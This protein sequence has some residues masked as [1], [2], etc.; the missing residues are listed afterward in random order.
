MNNSIKQWRQQHQRIRDYSTIAD[1]IRALSANLYDI[2]QYG[3][4]TISPDRYPL[5]SVKTKY[6][7]NKPTIFLSAL[8]HGHEINGGEALIR[9]LESPSSIPVLFDTFNVV[10]IPCINPWGYE[11]DARRNSN[12][13]DIN[14]DVG[15]NSPQSEESRF[16]QSVINDTKK[17]NVCV[18]ACNDMHET[19]P[20]K[21]TKFRQETG[22]LDKTPVNTTAVAK[23]SH[24][25]ISNDNHHKKIGNV[26][27][28]KMRE[29]G[30]SIIG[31]GEQ[32]VASGSKNGLVIS[33][34]DI[35]LRAFC[36]RSFLELLA[37]HQK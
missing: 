27:I 31:D 11:H 25:M 16:V 34:S 37:S 20:I 28:E 23:Q 13:L 29:H 18:M 6:N 4:L 22:K 36:Q 30:A 32:V 12:A 15:A 33:Q 10:A 35:T 3:A 8:N 7:K 17:R 14:R 24:I 21:D 19:Y 2:K 5:Y 26:M 1:R 9:L